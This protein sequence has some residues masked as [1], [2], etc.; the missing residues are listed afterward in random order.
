MHKWAPSLMN[1]KKL[2]SKYVH[3]RF[4]LNKEN[5]SDSETD[6]LIKAI[7]IAELTLCQALMD[8]GR[9]KTW[10]ALA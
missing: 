6:M 7:K 10:D 4:W 1:K 9:Q 2:F 8:P 5:F 3:H